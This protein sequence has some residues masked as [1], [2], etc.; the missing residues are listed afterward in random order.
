MIR[1]VA[2]D[3]TRSLAVRRRNDSARNYLPF[4]VCSLD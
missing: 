1:S 3:W 2:E 4:D